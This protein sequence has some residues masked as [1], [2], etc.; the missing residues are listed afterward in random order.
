MFHYSKK[1]QST[2]VWLLFIGS[3]IIFDIFISFTF[4]SVALNLLEITAVMNLSSFI[5]AVTPFILLSQYFDASRYYV[6]STSFLNYLP[7][8]WLVGLVKKISGISCH[9]DQVKNNMFLLWLSAHVKTWEV[10]PS[11]LEKL[12]PQHLYTMQVLALS[13]NSMRDIKSIQGVQE[14]FLPIINK[15]L[16]QISKFSGFTDEHK[17][18]LAKLCELNT[19]KEGQVTEVISVMA[20]MIGAKKHEGKNKMPLL[21]RLKPG[22]NTLAKRFLDQP[23]GRMTSQMLQNSGVS[24]PVLKT[25]SKDKALMILN[26]LSECRTKVGAMLTDKQWQ[27]LQYLIGIEESGFIETLDVFPMND[28]VLAEKETRTIAQEVLGGLSVVH[29]SKKLLTEMIGT[30][31]EIRPLDENQKRMLIFL[32]DVIGEALNDSI[33]R[34]K[35]KKGLASAWADIS[36]M[37]VADQEVIHQNAKEMHL[38]SVFAAM[39]YVQDCSQSIK[40]EDI[41][42]LFRL[43]FRKREWIISLKIEPDLIPLVHKQPISPRSEEDMVD[44]LER[45]DQ[46]APNTLDGSFQ[47]ILS[48]REHPQSAHF[49][50]YKKLGGQDVWENFKKQYKATGFAPYYPQAADSSRVWTEIE[51]LWKKHDFDEEAETEINDARAKVKARLEFIF[52]DQQMNLDNV[53]PPILHFLWLQS[54][55]ETRTDIRDAVIF[56][57][58]YFKSLPNPDRENY[59][60]SLLEYLTK[61]WEDCPNQFMNSIWSLFLT[62]S[63]IEVTL[64][65]QKESIAEAVVKSY[66]SQLGIE[67]RSPLEKF[68]VFQKCMFQALQ[69][70]VREQD[71]GQ[72]DCDRAEK[73]IE[74]AVM[75]RLH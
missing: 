19:V 20:Q 17:Y 15:S 67:D 16:S 69:E 34:V 68:G 9:P 47:A 35:D 65:I 12:T 40:H 32:C 33:Q 51:P 24:E 13:G 38:D 3:S 6:P 74:K 45:S 10:Q 37:N 36:R 41:L 56:L 57:W 55:P 14:K 73:E 42:T 49:R 52:P 25:Y 64:A 18:L 39:Q 44:Y 54:E 43:P 5:L 30:P 4:Y 1:D 46:E 59:P 29:V 27:V 28:G 58:N 50:E 53:N 11:F 21:W 22:Q 26:R 48:E 31:D 7:S 71:H 23:N 72:A 66:Q 62:A 8:P 60:K 70:S 63:G 75:L 61:D 2:L